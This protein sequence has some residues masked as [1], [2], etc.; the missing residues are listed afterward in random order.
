MTRADGLLRRCSSCDSD[1]PVRTE[2]RKSRPGRI[3]VGIGPSKSDS[4]VVGS[5]SSGFVGLFAGFRQ[6]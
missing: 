6:C 2:E 4:Y 3:L 1:R 5:S